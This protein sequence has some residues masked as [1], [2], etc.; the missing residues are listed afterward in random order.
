MLTTALFRRLL[1]AAALFNVL[2]AVLLGFPGSPLGQMAGLP[3]EVPLA[4]RAIVAV[5]VLLF[6]GCYAWL[7]AQPEPNRPMVVLGAVGKI[8]VV[9][10]V[11]GLWW[12]AQ[13]P[14]AS[15]AAVSGDL[16]F[17]AC[18]LWWLKNSKRESAR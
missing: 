9:A 2:G 17:A 4:Y 8:A 13:A 15:L 6:A 5:F 7:A 3:A 16:V 14:L 12:A 11:I 1:W 18:F 10:V